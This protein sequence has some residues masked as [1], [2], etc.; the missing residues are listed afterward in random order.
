MSSVPIHAAI[1]GPARRKLTLI[2][3]GVL[4]AMG[5][6]SMDL[7]LPSL[8]VLSGEL[9]T[10]DSAVQSTM[11]A[12]LIGLAL[13]QLIYGPL[14]DRVGR[15]RP[16]LIGIAAF[17]LAS[18]LCAV[19][20][21]IELLIIARLIQ[22]IAGSAGIV[23][24][25]AVVRDLYGPR[26]SAR[27]FS[28]LGAITGIAPILAPIAGAA[29]LAVVDW[30]GVFVVLGGLSVGILVLSFFGVPESLADENRHTGGIRAQAMEM[31]AALSNRLFLTFALAGGLAG[32]A[33]F[34]YISMSSLVFQGEYALTAQQFS[35]VFASNAVG[36]V[37]VSQLNAMLTR[38]VPL[39]YLVITGVAITTVSSLCIAILGVLGAALLPVLVVL[40][41]AVI[42]VGLHGPNLQGLA[43]APFSRNAG[44]AAAVLGMSQFVIGAIIPPLASLGGVSLTVMG[45]TMTS[46]ALVALVLVIAVRRHR[47]DP[48]TDSAGAP[49]APAVGAPTIE[50]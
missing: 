11:S 47:D 48:Q 23:I 50:G 24:A 16:V 20:P 27:I 33:L 9:H 25:R 6:L 49:L 31:R 39:I 7:Y 28:I 37:V 44:S 30:R 18:L 14:S 15:R 32:S 42:T 4:S 8:P 45:I 26:D 46:C 1:M 19:A 34:T 40:F 41:F 12:C 10:T 5:P 36:M 35:L 43:L 21:S 38:R 22:G 13:G 2:T 17:V 3:L 29:L